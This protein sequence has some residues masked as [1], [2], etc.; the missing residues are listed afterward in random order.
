MSDNTCNSGAQV[1]IAFLVGAATGAA[2]ALMTAPKPGKETRDTI[3]GWTRDAQDTMEM[4]PAALKTAYD[5]AA[6][7]A[8]DAFTESIEQSRKQKEEGT[9]TE[10][11]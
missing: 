8:K 6:T 11:A 7:A 5:S 1:L 2:I 9:A 4:V 3:R 10:E